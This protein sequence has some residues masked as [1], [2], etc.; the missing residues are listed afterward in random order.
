MITRLLIITLFLIPPTASIA[1]QPAS[2]TEEDIDQRLRFIEQRLN[3]AKP[4]AQRWQYG[5]TALFAANTAF[6]SFIAIRSSSGDNEAQYT[7][8]AV[9]SAGALALMLLRPLPAVD[10][11]EPLAAMP[12]TTLEQKTARL[13]AA[14]DLLRTNA[15]RARERTSFTRHLL[16]VTVHLV[17]STAIAALGDVRDAAISNLTGIAVSQV[18]I[19]SQPW[20]AIGD[21]EA[22]ERQFPTAST[23]EA[24]SWQ[25]TPIPGGLGVT[26]HF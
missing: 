23:A 8:E 11:A 19:W 14:E 22:Y 25:L 4:G 6:S 7:V 10:G 20:R 18:H 21:L 17:G 1:G 5:W 24:L 16:A 9:K 12:D 13:E 2:L 3:A 26:I 15:K